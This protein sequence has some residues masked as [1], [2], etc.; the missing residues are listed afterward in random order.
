MPVSQIP[1]VVD[2]ESTLEDLGI[3]KQSA[4]TILNIKED[5]IGPGRLSQT[6][7]FDIPMIFSATIA[8]MGLP[9]G[10][11][12][13]TYTDDLPKVWGD[14]TQVGRVLINLIKNAWEALEKNKDAKRPG[15]R[16]KRD[17][18]G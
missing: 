6:E 11:I 5:L 10:V 14:K 17:L 3:I 15:V 1:L 8:G 13:S 18:S 4:E 16:M 9:A 2:I 12:T 7:A